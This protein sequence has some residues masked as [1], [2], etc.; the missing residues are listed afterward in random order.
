MY[1]FDIGADGSGVEALTEQL[2]GLAAVGIQTVIGA[3]PGR[4]PRRTLE[5]IGRRVLPAVA[6]L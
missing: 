4:D 6:D 1:G 2:R 5:L 3:I